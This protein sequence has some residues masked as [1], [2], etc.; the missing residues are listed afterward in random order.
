MP[1]AKSFIFVPA[2]RNATITMPTEWVPEHWAEQIRRLLADNYPGRTF[3]GLLPGHTLKA[4]LSD[5]G[6][7]QACLQVDYGHH[8]IRWLVALGGLA[9]SF[10]PHASLLIREVLNGG[11]VWTI[12]LS[13]P[14]PEAESLL[15]EL[16]F[17]EVVDDD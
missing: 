15:V 14:V 17:Q 1:D 7:L 6:A 2:D 5:D 16:G 12:M 13:P 11:G 10:R 4:V 3:G 8:E 9:G